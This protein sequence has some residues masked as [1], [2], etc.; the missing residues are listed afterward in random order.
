M[1]RCQNVSVV[2]YFGHKRE[3][4]AEQRAAGAVPSTAD[5]GNHE[6][7]Y[8]CRKASRTNVIPRFLLE[9][10]PAVESEVT[11]QLR[12]QLLCLLCHRTI[13][14][15]GTSR[16]VGSSCAADVYQLYHSIVGLYHCVGAQQYLF[17]ARGS[18]HCVV[19]LQPDGL[20][21]RT[22]AEASLNLCKRAQ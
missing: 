11:F 10:V 15:D 6:P 22:K 9:M 1:N 17:S 2:V 12:L 20:R 8:R 13:G 7:T 3:L 21:S 14:C 16:V 18:G 19:T 4:F 5:G